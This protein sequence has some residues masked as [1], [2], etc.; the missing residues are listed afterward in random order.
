MVYQE[1]VDNILQLEKSKPEDYWRDNAVAP[2]F[3]RK[4]FDEYEEA[5]F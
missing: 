4:I 3:S 2:L 1:I 5:P